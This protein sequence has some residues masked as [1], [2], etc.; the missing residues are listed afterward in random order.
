MHWISVRFYEMGDSIESVTISW[1]EPFSRD[2]QYVT[3]HKKITLSLIYV[4]LMHL[5]NIT[6]KIRFNLKTLY[7]YFNI[8]YVQSSLPEI[9]G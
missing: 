2:G 6:R 1:F 3:V 5:Y 9:M 7:L 4:A 8:Y